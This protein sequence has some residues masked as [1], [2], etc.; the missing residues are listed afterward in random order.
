MFSGYK[1]SKDTKG[2]PVRLDFVYEAITS[3]RR[4]LD[5]KTE[6]ARKL[7]PGDSEVYRTF[8]A[9]NFPAFIPAGV[10]K[11]GKRTD[12][13]LQQ[14]SGYVILDMDHLDDAMP[15][16]IIALRDH[17]N[18]KMLFVSPSG[19]G[20]KVLCPVDPVPKNDAEHRVA[21]QACVELFGD[22]VEELGCEVDPGGK[23]VSRLC[24]IS[25]DPQ[26]VLREQASPI[27]WEMPPPQPASP[28][29]QKYN[30]NVD[31]TPL[32]FIKPDTDIE[33]EKAYDVWIQVGM[34]LKEIG[35]TVE[36]WDEWSKKTDKPDYYK[37]GECQEKW[38]SFKREEGKK[39]AWTRIIKYAKAGGYEP[40][41]KTKKREN[42]IPALKDASRYFLHDDF[43]VLAMSDFIQEK[44]TVWAQDSGV[45]I[46]DKDQGIYVPGEIEIDRAVREELG[47]LRKSLYVTE[48]LKDLSA[49]CRRDVP[50]TS[51]LIAFQ[52]GVVTL[53]PEK[54]AVN[55]DEHSPDNYL[56]SVFPV[57]FPDSDEKLNAETEG[58]KD[59]DAWLLEVL[60]NDEGLKSLIYQ[61]IGSV[62][63][64][65]SVAMQRG[66]LLVGEGGTGKSM[67]LSQIERLVGRHNISA[68]A[69]GDYGKND[70][71]FGTLY[72]KALALDSDIDVAVPLSG[73]IKPA[74]TGNVITCNQKYKA[75]FDF[76]PYATWIGSI[77]RFPRTR[78][79]TW[80]FFRRWIS[81][82]F[83][84]S[85]KTD[86][87]FESTKRNL[88]SDPE[89][90]TAILT[91]SI[92]EYLRAY[93]E[94]GFIV[95]EAAEKLSHEMY[96]SANSVIQWIDA[97]THSGGEAY[98]LRSVAY[99][100]YAT[101]CH[102][103]EFEP[104]SNKDFYAT[105]RTQGFNP[106]AQK[107]V[108]GKQERV[109]LGLELS[110]DNVGF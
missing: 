47:Q 78:D 108:D 25:H 68:T 98:A 96:Q 15:D 3:G 71:A 23:N 109:I 80:G 11:S 86:S 100:A 81:I 27:A 88:W 65:G 76:N 84:K 1:N 28:P 51:H 95:A 94:G 2:E 64:K 30:G 41:A 97:E 104:H 12:D 37:P 36:D 39:V 14:H 106:D 13:G 53:L 10:F 70:F 92:V 31:L 20:L 79:K 56:M 74:V 16:M 18:V 63:H 105:L 72:G 77:N 93:C 62:F 99:Q 66:V 32:D 9:E 33:G 40:P 5:E 17:P 50:D 4:E 60:A 91:R 49:T 75:Q 38:D 43:N 42:P 22:L 103:K 101:W 29:K 44:F 6:M 46:Y 59:F 48:V 57:D 19:N 7:Y 58:S 52:N 102:D 110:T 83:N 67:L 61:I 45:W 73:A 87:K 107:R 85:F 82:P 26:A 35:A 24:F 89:T 69:W 54:G 90:K 34:A 21:W 8:K 55:F